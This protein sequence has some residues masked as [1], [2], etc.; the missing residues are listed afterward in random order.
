[1]YPRFFEALKS[2][3]HSNGF[4]HLKSPKTCDTKTISV[5]STSDA[6]CRYVG[7]ICNFEKE[8]FLPINSFDGLF[9][10][11]MGG[12]LLKASKVKKNRIK[13]KVELSWKASF[14]IRPSIYQ[15][16]GYRRKGS[17]GGSCTWHCQQPPHHWCFIRIAATVPG[18]TWQALQFYAIPCLQFLHMGLKNTLSY[19]FRP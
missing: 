3:D 5:I 1:M 15:C 14:F 6:I 2:C 4:T 7:V 8:G 11:A 19:P 12:I 18:P 13:T 17:T 10:T 16:G 9:N